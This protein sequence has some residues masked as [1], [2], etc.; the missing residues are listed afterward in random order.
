[1]LAL[2]YV[3]ESGSHD[4]S[5]ILSLAGYVFLKPGAERFTRKLSKVLARWHLP[6]FHMV[7]CAHRA[8]P[9]DHLTREECIQ[10]E[11]QVIDL[12]RGN[13]EYGFAVGLNKGAYKD[14]L[15]HNLAGSLGGEYSFCVRECFVMVRRWIERTNF[16]GKVAYFC[17]AGHSHEKEAHAVISDMLSSPDIKARYRYF[18]HTFGSK[19]DFLPLQGADLL[20]WQ[21]HSHLK[22]DRALPPRKDFVALLREQDTF[23]DLGAANVNE[24]FDHLDRRYGGLHLAK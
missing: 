9:F 19:A 23:M 15:T 17:E 24:M 20:A 12:V 14:R 7:D 2:V 18:S 13:S 6:Y 4:D 8:P 3:D 22:R 5:E 16:D 11:K 10:V 21:F 1:M